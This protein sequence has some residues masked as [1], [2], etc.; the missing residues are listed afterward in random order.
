MTTV[1]VESPNTSLLARRARLAN[2][3]D[4]FGPLLT[5]DRIVGFLLLV[6]CALFAFDDVAPL[7]SVGG[8]LLASPSVVP[9]AA[10]HLIYT[11]GSKGRRGLRG[12]WGAFALWGYGCIVTAATLTFL[13]SVLLGESATEKAIRVAVSIF[14]YAYILGAGFQLFQP[15]RQWILVGCAVALAILLASALL[16]GFG[17]GFLD[18]SNVFHSVA[19]V[20][21]RV[22]GTRLEASSLGAAILVCTAILAMGLSRNQG[23]AVLA[24]G[25]VLAGILVNSRGTVITIAITLVV[26]VLVIISRSAFRRRVRLRLVFSVS[27]LVGVLYL[28]FGLDQLLTSDLWLTYGSFN[29][30]SG[31]TSEATRSIWANTALQSTLSYPS[32]TGYV[33]YL[34][35]MPELLSH[36]TDNAGKYYSLSSL[37]EALGL[38]GATSDDQL[39]PKTL[40]AIAAIF[41]GIPGLLGVI[42]L[43]FRTLNASWVGFRSGQI[44][45]PA[46][47]MILIL[48]SATYFA[49]ISS[50]EHAFG[51]GALLS[52]ATASRRRTSETRVRRQDSGI[53]SGQH[54]L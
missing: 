39:V 36:A 25:S 4:R 47:A 3:S 44:G 11:F 17:I 28:S 15:F 49:S 7:K 52:F 50:W 35:W 5:V 29:S 8:A 51:F 13:P 45:L 48:V 40:P 33:G 43:Y 38:V 41:L 46:A 16:G 34:A 42:F 23:I 14:L 9:I 2:S 6:G 27:A 24:V 20:Q 30:H 21:Q 31:S 32:G 1:R 12:V 53:I 26:I 18:T 10:A 22:R 19:N 37:S 54:L